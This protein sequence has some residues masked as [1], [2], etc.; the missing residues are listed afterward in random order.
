M[1]R[2]L[3]VNDNRVLEGVVV[4]DTFTKRLMGYMFRKTPHCTALL[5][6][7]CNSI[8]T[9]FMKFD[10]DVLFLDESMRVVEKKISLP[11]RKMIMPVKDAVMV[12]EAIGGTFD[13]IDS[14][15]VIRIEP[16]EASCE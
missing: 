15:D 7:P 11:K 6:K 16:L 8:H 5:I 9:F 3:Y 12:L 14:G 4:A 1:G 2:S 10:I 13:D